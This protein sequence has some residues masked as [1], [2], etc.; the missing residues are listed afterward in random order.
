VPDPSS[1]R[2]NSNVAPGQKKILLDVKGPGV[3]THIWMTFLGPEP[4]PWAKNGSANHQEMLLRMYWDGNERPAVE[5]R[6][7]RRRHAVLLRT[8]P[9]GV[10]RPE[11]K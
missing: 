6:A 9:P 11:W 1:N 5:E 2:D 7:N 3:I 10:P 4:H 8:V